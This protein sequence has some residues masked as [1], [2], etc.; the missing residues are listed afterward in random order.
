MLQLARDAGFVDETHHVAR[1]VSVQ[2]HLHRHLPLDGCVLGLQ[3][4]PHA[5]PADKVPDF[6]AA[7]LKSEI[8]GEFLQHNGLRRRQGTLRVHVGDDL[9]KLHRHVPELNPLSVPDLSFP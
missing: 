7:G 2:N 4:R 5:A 9:P 3:H 1:G 8:F 6:V